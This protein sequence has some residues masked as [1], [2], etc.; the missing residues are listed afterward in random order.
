MVSHTR[1]RQGRAQAAVVL[2][3]VLVVLAVGARVGVDTASH[4]PGLCPTAFLGILT[5]F[6]FVELSKTRGQLQPP[7]G[8]K[9]SFDHKPIKLLP[10]DVE[11]VEQACKSFSA[12]AR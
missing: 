4:G 6:T 7:T 3:V 8:P 10:R 5:T 1:G 9:Y 12:C 2:V 11:S